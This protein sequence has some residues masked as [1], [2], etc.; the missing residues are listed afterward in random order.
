MIT[1][2]VLNNFKKIIMIVL[3]STLLPYAL[4]IGTCPIQ[5]RN[6]LHFVY[7]FDGPTEVIAMLK[8]DETGSN[9]G[10]WMLGYV[11]NA[12]RFIT[13]RCQYANGQQL[14]KEIHNKI[15][16]CTYKISMHKNLQLDCR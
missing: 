13:F 8:P 2:I 11:Y 16:K 14:E 9:S 6:P 1:S 5:Q 10:F 3:L 15:D 4:A 7:V 12:G